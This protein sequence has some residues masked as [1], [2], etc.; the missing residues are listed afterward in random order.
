MRYALHPNRC[1]E[2]IYVEE[3]RVYFLYTE[4][5]K[6][7]WGSRDGTALNVV[8]VIDQNKEVNK[9]QMISR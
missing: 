2:C 4:E 7:D 8:G 5:N 1:T 6:K 9:R 3:K